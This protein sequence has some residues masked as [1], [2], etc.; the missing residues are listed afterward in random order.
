MKIKLIIFLF[1]FFIS[2]ISVSFAQSHVALHQTSGVRFFAGNEAFKQ[3][4][5]EAAAGDT[6]YISGGTFLVP[7]SIRKRITVL[8]AGH[9]PDFTKA[10]GQTI[11]DGDLVLAQGAS[12]SYFE[13]CLLLNML[14]FAENEKVD[15]VVFRRCRF[16]QQVDF[17]GNQTSENLC[18]NTRFIESVFAL[19]TTH[20]FSHSKN[21]LISNSIIDGRFS[22][23]HYATLSNC[24]FLTTGGSGAVFYSGAHCTVQNS[25]INSNPYLYA[26][27]NYTFKNNVFFKNIAFGSTHYYSDNSINIPGDGFFVNQTGANFSYTHDYNL[28]NPESYKGNDGKQVGIYGG[29]H[30]WKEGSVP[31]IPHIS[32]KSISHTVDAQGNLKIEVDISAQEY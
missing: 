9:N 23:L 1:L 32:R 12:K 28:K 11:F 7:G 2:H 5:N 26:N 22:N 14:V 19:N 6:L 21:T 16:N 27:S 10:T 18:E 3:A 25:I 30:P 13:G 8:G 24:I 29:E 17:A 31:M 4:Y 15:D 20:N